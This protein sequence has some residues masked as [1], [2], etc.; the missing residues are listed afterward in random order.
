MLEILYKIWENPE[1]KSTLADQPRSIPLG[2]SSTYLIVGF[3]ILASPTSGTG[4]L[5]LS[6]HSIIQDALLGEE[7]I[8][9]WLRFMLT[10]HFLK[11]DVFFF[12]LYRLL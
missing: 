5:A 3:S 7:I 2:P 8:F 10:F 6:L 9:A 1:S 4:G 11:L 12:F